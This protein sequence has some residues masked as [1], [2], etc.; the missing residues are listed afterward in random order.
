MHDKGTNLQTF[1]TSGWSTNLSI[2]L[3][4]IVIAGAV[5]AAGIFNYKAP[6]REQVSAQPAGQ[7]RTKWQRLQWCNAQRERLE[8]EVR[9]WKDMYE[10]EN[11]KKQD[12]KPKLV[13]H[14]AIYG[15]GPKAEADVT[16][17]LQNAPRDA[18]AFPI[19][20]NL[21]GGD[22]PAFGVRKS[23]D[24]DYSYGS[25]HIFHISRKEPKSGEISL[26]VL[27][28]DTEIERLDNE[29]KRLALPESTKVNESLR[30]RTIALYDAL[31][32][33][34]DDHG[35]DPTRERKPGESQDEWMN[36]VMKN[37]WKEKLC[38]DYRIRY[39]VMVSH[40]RDEIA[41]HSA[42]SNTHLDNA[43]G[44]AGSVT[45]CSPGDIQ[46]IRIILWRIAATMSRT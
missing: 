34:L 9:K 14:R 6:H 7:G 10:A 33:L 21:T 4:S 27:P 28:E 16:N 15:A 26:M 8:G 40:F 13:I 11:T 12:H 42:M 23:L 35:P 31:G 39:G 5:L 2:F 41:M 46:E 25:D 30:T 20:P 37:P 24:V 17:F 45:Q 18:I 38:A 3:P 22:D 43:I 19:G 29:L 36:R 44:R 32:K 1:W